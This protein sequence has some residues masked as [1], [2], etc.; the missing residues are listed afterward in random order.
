[1]RTDD[2]YFILIALNIITTEHCHQR[3]HTLTRT[4]AHTHTNVLLIH[5]QINGRKC[6]IVKLI[7]SY[8]GLFYNNVSTSLRKF[9][10]AETFLEYI[11]VFVIVQK[12]PP[13]KHPHS[14]LLLISISCFEIVSLVL[15]KISH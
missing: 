6:R 9:K 5:R 2:L 7:V 12:S 13:T 4:H 8:V 1:M 14:I 15:I 10:R 11:I 3:A